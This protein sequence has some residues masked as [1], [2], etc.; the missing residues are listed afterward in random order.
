MIS[1]QQKD[2]LLAQAHST[3]LEQV[4]AEHPKRDWDEYEIRVVSSE[5]GYDIN[6]RD[7]QNRIPLRIFGRILVKM[8][9]S[10]L[11]PKLKLVSVGLK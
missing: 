11:V 8:K 7:T 3:M 2:T 10:Q 4:K 6:L 9:D 1:T 5:L